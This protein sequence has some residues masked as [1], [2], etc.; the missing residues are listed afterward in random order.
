MAR[1]IIIGGHGK[2]ALRLAPILA[3]R[4]DAVVSV[5]RNPDHAADVAAT[6]ADPRP[7]DI[8][9]LD[10]AG[11]DDL[12]R[13]VDA[14]VWSAG[15][16]GG[17]PTRTR[18][19][20]YEAAVASMDACIRQGVSRYVMVSYLGA[21]R[22]HG[23]DPSNSFYAY[24]EAKAQADDYLRATDLAWTIL[25]PGRL[26]LDEPSGLIEVSESPERSDVTRADVAAV[27]AEV[28]SRPETAG[29]TIPF[30][31]GAT[32]IEDAITTLIS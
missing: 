22:D 11:W 2:V 30:N 17:N 28:L 10:A 16:G 23:I 29:L 1:I 18:A 4:G 5:F 27:A 8:E 24:A 20:D 15:A 13:G 26:T 3:G 31:N 32:P 9:T 7:V 21:R 25:G 19:V 14:V 12:V 6:G